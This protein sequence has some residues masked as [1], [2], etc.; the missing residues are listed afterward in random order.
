M[1]A[2]KE[3]ILVGTINR[4]SLSQ[5]SSKPLPITHQ[6]QIRNSHTISLVSTTSSASLSS[7]SQAKAVQATPNKYSNRDSTGR[8]CGCSRGKV[9]RDRIRAGRIWHRWVFW[10]ANMGYLRIQRWI[11]RPI[12]SRP[13]HR[14]GSSAKAVTS[15]RVSCSTRSATRAG[16]WSRRAAAEIYRLSSGRKSWAGT[17]LHKPATPIIKESSNSISHSWRQKS[18]QC[19]RSKILKH[20]YR[21]GWPIGLSRTRQRPKLNARAGRRKMKVLRMTSIR[22]KTNIHTISTIKNSSITK[23]STNSNKKTKITRLARKSRAHEKRA[24]SLA[25]STM[26]WSRN[27][28][29]RK[30]KTTTWCIGAGKLHSCRPS[31]CPRSTS[32]ATRAE[33]STTTTPP[34]S[35]GRGKTTRGCSYSTRCCSDDD[36]S[37]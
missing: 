5:L 27:C 19:Y 36:F 28:V 8:E 11:N 1:P 23:E 32:P 34:K 7:K 18:N 26:S 25:T 14:G 12:Y 29:I 17:K 20:S 37:I 33:Y 9:S 2:F 31:T 6:L 24:D 21:N 16:R 15:V 13:K 3:A 4:P 30:A 35:T 10:I 22:S